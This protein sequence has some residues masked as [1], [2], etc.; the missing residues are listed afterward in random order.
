[1]AVRYILSGNP[2]DVA[3]VIKE[4]RIRENRGVVSFTPIAED[5]HTDNSAVI[6]NLQEQIQAKDE[7]IAQLQ[8][9]LENVTKGYDTAP[10]A[11]AEE[12]APETEE[13]QVP[14]VEDLKEVNIDDDKEV[15]ETDTKEVAEEDTKTTKSKRAKK[16]E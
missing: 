9:E 3:K 14:E 1:M 10:E 12:T 16:T 13:A 4:N 2:I 7:Q 6:A 5:V 15:A 11:E 8:A